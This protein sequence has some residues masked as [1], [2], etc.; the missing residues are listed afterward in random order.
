MT[1]RWTSGAEKNLTAI[2]SYLLENAPEQAHRTTRKILRATNLLADFPHVGRP[3]NR[4]GTREFVLTPLPYIIVYRVMKRT[5][6][7]LRIFHG[8]QN[9]K[10]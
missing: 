10:Q 4:L 6:Q 3:G 9:W 1:T 2:I 5:V 8:R 7:I